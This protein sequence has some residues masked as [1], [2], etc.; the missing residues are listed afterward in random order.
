MSMNGMLQ[1]LIR[2]QSLMEVQPLLGGSR[3]RR[4][5]CP[6]GVLAELDPGTSRMI[7][8]GNAGQLRAWLDGFIAGR[9]ITVGSGG[10]RDVDL[11][12]LNPP[13]DEVWELRKRERPSTRIFGRFAMKDVFIAT[14]IR[15]AEDL[16]AVEWLSGDRVT[17]PVWRQ[18][19]RRCKAVWRSLFLDYQPVS[20]GRPDDYVSNAIDARAG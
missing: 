7:G 1:E 17:W 6:P 15:T 12:I 19:I 8:A 3:V 13:A 18:E 11:K 4:V 2:R 16:F 20:G 10:G 9:R 5:L 14:N